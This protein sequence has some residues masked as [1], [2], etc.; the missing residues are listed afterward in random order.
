MHIDLECGFDVGMAEDLAQRFGVRA[1]IDNVK[2]LLA[3]LPD[4]SKAADGQV[5]AAKREIE[6]ADRAYKALTDEQKG[7]ITVGDVANYNELVE[8]LAKLTKTS[9]S[10]ITGNQTVPGS[11]VIEP[12]TTVKG[13]SATA[14]VTDKTVTSAIEAVKDSNETAITI[15]PTDIGNAKNVSVM[16]PKTA[17]QSIV[18][19]T[20][21]SL[22]IETNDGN[23]TISNDALKSIAAQAIGDSITITVEQ[24]TAAD[25]A[26]KSID[27]TDAVVVEVTVTSGST[28]VTEFGGKSLTIS[29]PAGRLPSIFPRT[30]LSFVICLQNNMSK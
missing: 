1:A 7:Y 26:D 15:V 18:D 8:R 16:L 12:T 10:T 17:A 9:A 14:T 28:A 2:A 23:V 29:I 30:L 6:A 27:T 24:K 5:K 4:S 13:S 21:V 11:S 3:A 19:D 20:N 22:V 25:V